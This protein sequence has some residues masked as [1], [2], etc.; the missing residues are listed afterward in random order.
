M[1]PA[2]TMVYALLG[3]VVREI[4]ILVAALTY[5]VLPFTYGFMPLL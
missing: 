5:V 1:M 3:K 4:S 2:D